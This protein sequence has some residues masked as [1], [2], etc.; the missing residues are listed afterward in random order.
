VRST[1]AEILFGTASF[2]GTDTEALRQPLSYLHHGHLAPPE[3][4]VVARGPGA[5][6]MN[7]L[8]PGDVDRRTALLQIPSLIKGYL[9]LGG[10]VGEGAWVDRAFNTVDVC[11]VMDTARLNDRTARIYARESA[12]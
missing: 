7:L 1:G 8:A 4:R 9:R 5:V 6:P 10:A 12:G 2:H 3:L 11:L